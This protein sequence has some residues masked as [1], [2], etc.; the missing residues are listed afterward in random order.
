MAA[1]AL[2]NA[3]ISLLESKAKGVDDPRKIAQDVVL[4]S[5]M[6]AILPGAVGGGS[7]AAKAI[8]KRRPKVIQGEFPKV[9]PEILGEF[10][11]A[12][13]IPIVEG[14]FP[15]AE[16]IQIVK[17]EPIDKVPSK[18][19]VIEAE[20][21]EVGGKPGPDEKPT[22]EG[23]REFQK[24]IETEGKPVTEKPIAE[25][26][27]REAPPSI[28]EGDRRKAPRSAEE[29]AWTEATREAHRKA[30]AEEDVALHGAGL[31]DIEVD[32]SGTQ[33]LRLKEDVRK[34]VR[35]ATQPFARH[36]QQGD[37]TLMAP[38]T[39]AYQLLTRTKEFE[40]TPGPKYSSKEAKQLIHS[41][42]V[43]GERRGS[44][45]IEVVWTGERI[46]PADPTP[47][48]LDGTTPKNAD[49]KET[50]TR[51]SLSISKV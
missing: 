26:P 38:E 30:K 13:P 7:R 2:D 39:R 31:K 48:T 6:G 42:R 5:G 24:T 34:G 47:I 15:E 28:F 19:D 4:S 49:T 16:P 14:K 46:D 27:K 50:S 11:K 1:G 40:G 3:L 33:K 17:G 51:R 37:R 35:K 44:N 10:P 21:S 41:R 22:A 8:A 32:A 12:E 9:D 45:E 23:F 18:K 25:P 36:L 29:Q 43:V 20:F